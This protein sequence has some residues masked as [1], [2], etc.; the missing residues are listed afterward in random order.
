LRMHERAPW[1]SRNVYNRDLRNKKG[2]RRE[3]LFCVSYDYDGENSY[4]KHKN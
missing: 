3:N 1:E 2:K 4:L